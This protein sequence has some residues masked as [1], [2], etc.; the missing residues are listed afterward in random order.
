MKYSKAELHQMNATQLSNLIN[1]YLA[2]CNRKDYAKEE[3]LK[4]FGIEGMTWSQLKNLAISKGA[5]CSTYI[6]FWTK[7]LLCEKYNLI[8][9][10][11]EAVEHQNTVSP[12][13][14]NQLE[15]LLALSDFF[16]EEKMK[17]LE[18]IINEKNGNGLIIIRK[19]VNAKN[20][21]FKVSDD[22]LKRFGEFC[23]R[24]DCFTKV[25]ILDSALML[26]MDLYEKQEKEWEE[27]KDS[28]L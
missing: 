27:F 25:A 6:E 5:Y 1:S 14:Q 10:E 24:Q 20:C 22:V 23:K 3:T 12:L 21:T 13:N 9:R 17:K 7:A 11:Q 8:P 19:S 18:K 2:S 26:F 28:K 4:S 16:N 15:K